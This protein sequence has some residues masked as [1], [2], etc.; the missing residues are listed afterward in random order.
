[1]PASAQCLS[2]ESRRATL[3]SLSGTAAAHA[4][5]MG[6]VGNAGDGQPWYQMGCSLL[7]AAAWHWTCNVLH[8][9]PAALVIVATADL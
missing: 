6:E 4:L 2:L 7:T 1:M 8:L 3:G 5:E 9:A